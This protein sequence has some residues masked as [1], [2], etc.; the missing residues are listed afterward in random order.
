MASIMCGQKLWRNLLDPNRTRA[1]RSSAVPEQPIFQNVIFGP[2]AATLARFD[3][4]D[5]VIALDVAARLTVAF[6]FYTRER[7]HRDFAEA[8][9]YALEDLGVPPRIVACEA[10]VI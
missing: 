2:W 9:S 3:D 1:K 7:F 4:R 5:I 10:S 8:V 6:R